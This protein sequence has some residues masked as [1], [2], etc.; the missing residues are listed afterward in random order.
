VL[1]VLERFLYRLSISEFRDQFVLKGGML[2]AAFDERRPTRD[3]DLL[4]LATTIDADSVAAVMA[5]IAA[6]EVDDGVIFRPDQLT[7]RMIR[8]QDVYAAVRVAMPAS[9]ATAALALKVDVNVGD[10][11]T[12]APVEIT[13]PAL[14]DE[15]FTMLAYPLETVLAEKLVTMIA[16]GDTTTRD[17]DFADVWLLTGRRQLDAGPLR[18]AIIATAGYRDV[19]LVPIDDVLSTLATDRQDGWRRYITRTGLADDVPGTL[20][21]VIADITAFAGPILSDVLGA[22]ALWNPGRRRW[23]T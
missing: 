18:E 2:L 13:Y 6:I 7:T 1:Y 11:V 14:L 8:E 19:M 21:E 10:P 15:P 4:G 20:A 23:S 9:L 22:R 12:P 17:R 3:V 16:R 5:E